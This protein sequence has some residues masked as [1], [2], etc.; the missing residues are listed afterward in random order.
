MTL[1]PKARLDIQVFAAL[2][3]GATVDGL[4]MGLRSTGCEA[5][6]PR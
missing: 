4:S 1:W 5:N 6:L 2:L 3:R